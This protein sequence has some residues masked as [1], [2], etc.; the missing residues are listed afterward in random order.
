MAINFEFDQ[1][2]F[3][4]WKAENARR[5]QEQEALEYI[6][7]NPQN[8]STEEHNQAKLDLANLLK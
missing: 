4:A 2:K 7:D 1:A 5:D 6:I 3:D 8:F